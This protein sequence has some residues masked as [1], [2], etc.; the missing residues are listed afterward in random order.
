MCQQDFF[1]GGKKK[2]KGSLN[3]YCLLFLPAADNRLRTPDVHSQRVG[4]PSQW[5][6]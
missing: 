4:L 1:Y 5:D 3:F 2:I 6:P